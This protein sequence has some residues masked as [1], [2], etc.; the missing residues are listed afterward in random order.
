MPVSLIFVSKHFTWNSRFW[1]RTL[2][3]NFPQEKSTN[4]RK[5]KPTELGGVEIGRWSPAFLCKPAW[6]CR[7]FSVGF[8]VAS[9]RQEVLGA[10]S[11]TVDSELTREERWNIV[12]AAP[13]YQ[14]PGER[15]VTIRPHHEKGELSKVSSWILWHV[16]SEWFFFGGLPSGC[17]MMVGFGEF[18]GNHSVTPWYE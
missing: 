9:V 1:S 7:G 14:I 3:Q 18:S 11:G 5:L 2:S 4:I 13:C 16:R 6:N 15:R 17:S 12:W 10:A 8:G